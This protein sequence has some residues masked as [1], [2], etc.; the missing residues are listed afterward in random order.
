MGTAFR[1]VSERRPTSPL[2]KPINDRVQHEF[3]E[4]ARRAIPPC[5]MQDI[6]AWAIVTSDPRSSAPIALME[7]KRSYLAVDDWTPYDDDRRNYAALDAL[8]AAAGIPM[9]VVY[10]TKGVTINDDTPLRVFV[11]EQIEPTYRFH[12]DVVMPAGVFAK[13]WPNPVDHPRARSVAA[14]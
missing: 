8:A 1:H 9:F 12:R 7:C 2:V 11:F 5:V 6:D 10:W 3:Q 4:W 14:A 13:R